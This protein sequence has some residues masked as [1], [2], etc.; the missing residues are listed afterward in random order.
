LFSVLSVS[1]GTGDR[2]ASNIVT[3]IS[4]IG[5]GVVFKE[6]ATVKGIT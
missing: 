1:I 6:G 3:G 2:I 4:F 5:A